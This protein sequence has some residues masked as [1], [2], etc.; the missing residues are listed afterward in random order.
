MYGAASS[1][2]EAVSGV[3]GAIP[4][5]GGLIHPH[6][7]EADPLS[8]PKC[9]REMKIVGFIEFGQSD[10]IP[11]RQGYGGQVERILLH[12][13]AWEEAAAR[14]PPAPEMTVG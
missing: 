14:A 13:G 7:H 5:F 11:L 6:I 1:H 10:V 8:C 12:C 9:R 4:T 2:P 3:V